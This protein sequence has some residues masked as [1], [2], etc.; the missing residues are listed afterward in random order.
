MTIISI[1][2]TR[3]LAGSGKLEE[4]ILNE[5]GLILSASTSN[6][7]SLLFDRLWR[8]IN[9]L[10][11]TKIYLTLYNL[12]SLFIVIL[13]FTLADFIAHALRLDWSVP[14]Y[15][16]RNKIIFALLFGVV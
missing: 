16:F 10:M 11:R 8:Y 6:P 15:Y 14:E 9:K 1:C 7:M 13:L 12:I 2:K 3:K 5:F 4:T